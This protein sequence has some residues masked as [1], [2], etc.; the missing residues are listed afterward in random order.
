MQG[1]GGSSN[2][3]SRYT[4]D[5]IAAYSCCK[6]KIDRGGAPMW[7]GTAPAMDAAEGGGCSSKQT[8]VEMG[9]SAHLC[10]ALK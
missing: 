6:Q 5:P 2:N 3:K 4:L 10:F 9:P 7:H 1:G 8:G